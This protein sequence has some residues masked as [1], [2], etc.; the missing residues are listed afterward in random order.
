MPDGGEVRIDRDEIHDYRW[1][2]IGA[3]LAEHASGHLPM[4]PPTYITLC[5]LARYA[6]TRSALAGER[7]TPC[8][9]ILPRMVS[10][11]GEGG[12]LTLYPGDAGYDSGNL[13]AEGPRHRAFLEN[14]GWC[15]QYAG[16]LDEP[17]LYPLDARDHRAST[18]VTAS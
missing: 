10:T 12:F 2:G 17:P 7:Q 9:R 1:M 16:V 13:A 3:A 11:E 14:G 4:L 15:Y 8:P 18:A 5:A 6:D